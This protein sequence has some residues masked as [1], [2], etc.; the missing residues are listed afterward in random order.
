MRKAL[1]DRRSVRLSNY[2]VT[3]SERRSGQSSAASAYARP[4][5]PDQPHISAALVQLQPAS[6]LRQRDCGTELFAG[7]ALLQEGDVDQLNEDASVL[8]GL[9]ADGN[10]NQLAGCDFWIS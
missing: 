9:N 6:L 7:P 3:T 8:H 2:G 1:I 4:L 10:F 5:S